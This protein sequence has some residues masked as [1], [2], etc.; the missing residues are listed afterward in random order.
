MGFG[1]ILNCKSFATVSGTK[2]FWSLFRL[3][4]ARFKKVVIFMPTLLPDN[5]RFLMNKFLFNIS[6]LSLVN[7]EIGKG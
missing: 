7:M 6:F 2:I 5:L 1:F 3:D 4:R